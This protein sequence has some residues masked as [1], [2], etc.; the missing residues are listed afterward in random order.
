MAQQQFFDVILGRI[1]QGLST[2]GQW[3]G[4]IRTVND[5]G[6]FRV[7]RIRI[8]L[9]QGQ[10]FLKASF[11]QQLL[12]IMMARGSHG[13]QA[14]Q[15]GSNRHYVDVVGTGETHSV[16]ELIELA[17]KNIDIDLAWKGKG[18]DEKGID[19]SRGKVYVTVSPEYFRPAEVDILISDPSKAK[20]MLGWK[21]KTSFK[22]LVRIMLE[23]DLKRVEKDIKFSLK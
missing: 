19:K 8:V 16:R 20:K 11:F 7:Q 3:N 17:F 4:R 9:G 14:L 10:Q 21:S 6:R 15:D 22:D 18:I 12:G 2:F 1:S 5:M 23:A 13:F